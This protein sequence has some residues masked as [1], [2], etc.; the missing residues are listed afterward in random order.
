LVVSAAMRRFAAPLLG[1]LLVWAGVPVTGT[2]TAGAHGAGCRMACCTVRTSARGGAGAGM[3]AAAAMR[4]GGHAGMNAGTHAGMKMTTQGRAS[5][6]D[7]AP[8]SAPTCRMGCGRGQQAGFLESTPSLL[9]VP[10]R[11]PAPAEAPFAARRQDPSRI[12]HPFD[13]PERPPRG[14]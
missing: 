5:R 10:P 6:S 1:A 12:L 2:A 8:P 9:A 4:A 13:L 11:L 3:G 7:S 14:A